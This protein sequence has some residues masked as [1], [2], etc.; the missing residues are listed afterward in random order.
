M[1][2]IFVLDYSVATTVA[3]TTSTASLHMLRRSCFYLTRQ[4]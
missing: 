4:Q 2:S 3:V 1:L